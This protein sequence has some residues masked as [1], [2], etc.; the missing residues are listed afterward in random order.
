MA[1]P[2]RITNS[3]AV[4]P[5][6]V[7]NRY[8]YYPE[9]AASN[10]ENILVNGDKQRAILNGKP[11]VREFLIDTVLELMKITILMQFISMIIF[12]LMIL[13]IHIQEINQVIILRI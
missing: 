10:P 5:E 11:A 3:N 4:S 2:Y 6:A 12:I 8:R 1:N 13:M 7:A 9:N